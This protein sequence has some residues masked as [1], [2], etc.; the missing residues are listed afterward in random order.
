MTLKGSDLC[1]ICDIYSCKWSNRMTVQYCIDVLAAHLACHC[2]FDVWPFDHED[3]LL[4]K[5]SVIKLST[6]FENPTTIV[7][8]VM[9]TYICLP[10][11]RELYHLTCD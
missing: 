5:Y 7:Y 1:T 2:D 8:R 4:I 10:W 11:L 6:K 3:L 9:A